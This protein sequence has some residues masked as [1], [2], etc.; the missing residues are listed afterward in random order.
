MKID[1]VNES[2]RKC[3]KVDENGWKGVK[4]DNMDESG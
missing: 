1:K 4:V 2:G 3:V